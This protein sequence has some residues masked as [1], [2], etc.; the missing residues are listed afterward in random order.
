[1]QRLSI[2][3]DASATAAIAAATAADSGDDDW[4]METERER[5]EGRH[6]DR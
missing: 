6:I 5:L 3:D 4:L 2:D 1:M